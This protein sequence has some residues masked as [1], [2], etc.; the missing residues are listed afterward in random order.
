MRNINDLRAI[1]G[2]KAGADPVN[3]QNQS[4]EFKYLVAAQRLL[5]GVVEWAEIRNSLTIKESVA[6]GPCFVLKKVPFW[7]KNLN[8]WGGFQ[9]LFPHI[10]DL[11]FGLL[12]SNEC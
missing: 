10:C 6:W 4:S 9:E 5:A 3:N 1:W 7:L 12:L 11:G 8:F 2:A